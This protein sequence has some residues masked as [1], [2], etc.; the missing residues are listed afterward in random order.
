MHLVL[1]L[2]LISIAVI[3]LVW[4]LRARKG[5]HVDEMPTCKNHDTPIPSY[6]KNHLSPEASKVL[7]DA[8]DAEDGRF[9]GSKT[10]N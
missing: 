4:L 1:L 6:V 7:D 3:I 10:W 5:R 9:Q 8:M 2:I